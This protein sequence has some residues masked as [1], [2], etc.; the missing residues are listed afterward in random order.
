MNAFDVQSH[1][2]S[3]RGPGP[4]PSPGVDNFKAGDP[5][6]EVRGIAVAWMSYTWALQQ[7]LDLGCN[8][9]ITHEP[10]YYDHLDA[11]PEVFRLE[12]VAEKRRLID[13]SGIVILRCHDLWDQFPGL[14][15]PDSWGRWLGFGEAVD[16]DRYSRVY[17][18][19]PRPAADLAEQVAEKVAA[20]GQPD[21]HL[22][23]PETK[24]VSRIAI[25]CGAITPFIE[26]L[27]KYRVDAAIC[28]E[29]GIAHWRDGALAI[30][31]GIPL[32]VVHHAASEEAGVAA[33]AAHLAARYPET[34]VHHLPQRCMY[35]S[36]TAAALLASPPG[37][38]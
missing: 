4:Y 20:F 9:F 24:T 11:N 21:V 28:S 37:S 26:Y 7:A 2:Y 30:D 15:I 13:E 36:V 35:R 16:G 29:D 19:E 33:L 34:P 27:I 12:G 31:L 3:L 10:T 18:I 1:L 17:T 32:I 22:I 6:T 23:G 8:L 5:R 25:G 14:G 38:R